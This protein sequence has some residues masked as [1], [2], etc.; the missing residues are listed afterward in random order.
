MFC[1]MTVDGSKAWRTT[2][3]TT[4]L[5]QQFHL[6]PLNLWDLWDLCDNKFLTFQLNYVSLASPNLLRLDKKKNKFFCFAL[7]F[8]YFGFAEVT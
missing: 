2:Y 1:G 7:N 5:R 6:Q 8:S 3:S 4:K